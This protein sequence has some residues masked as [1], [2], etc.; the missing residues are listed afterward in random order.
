[1]KVLDKNWFSTGLIDFE[2]K[3]YILLDYFQSVQNSYDEKK[4]FPMFQNLLYVYK[5]TQEYKRK[6]EEFK[7]SITKKNLVGIN[8]GGS[9]LE[10]EKSIEQD[11]IMD[12]IERVVNYSI[13]LF[14][15]SIKN[16][17][18]IY[19][20]I[21]N[22]IE[23]KCV[24]LEPI[25]KNEGYLI[26]RYNKEFIVYKYCVSTIQEDIHDKSKMIKFDEL[27][28]YK[29]TLTKNVEKIKMKL[30]KKYEEFPNPS[31]YFIDIDSNEFPLDDTIIPIIKRKILLNFFF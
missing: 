15:E 20:Q 12:E 1:V 17:R 25:Y 2:Y 16:G 14:K 28:K 6:I 24:G 3:Q 11:D 7:E 29:S 26:I 8:W 30:I 19:D 22:N 27:C 13:P 5:S 4:L 18:D 23:I 31:T 10:Y 9:K 21:D